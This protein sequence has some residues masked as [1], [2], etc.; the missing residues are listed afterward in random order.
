[1]LVRHGLDL[2]WVDQFGSGH[3]ETAMNMESFAIAEEL[4]RA[5]APPWRVSMG[6]FM[7]VHALLRPRILN[8]PAEDAAFDRLRAGARRLGLPWPPPPPNEVLVK[9]LA[10][11]W[12]TA[13]MREAGMVVPPATLAMLRQRARDHGQDG[14]AKP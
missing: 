4:I 12:P 6:G 5:G 10:G 2:G 3:L 13:A 11:E 9:V 7:P 1:M 14:T 8:K